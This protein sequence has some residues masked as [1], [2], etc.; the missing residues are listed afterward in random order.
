MNS[1]E[2]DT[3]LFY[4]AHSSFGGKRS[5]NSDNFPRRKGG[6]HRGRGDARGSFA[7]TGSFL[8]AKKKGIN[9]GKIIWS[10]L[11]QHHPSKGTKEI[12]KREIFLKEGESPSELTRGGGSRGT[13]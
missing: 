6:Y 7:V 13:C 8:M 1:Q 3:I 10:C 5:I 9:L 2:R 4:T 11:C 12:I